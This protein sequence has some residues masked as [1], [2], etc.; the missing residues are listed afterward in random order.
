MMYDENST[1]CNFSQVAAKIE[2]SKMFITHKLLT[3]APAT[4]VPVPDNIYVYMYNYVYMH[5]S[6]DICS[7]VA[8]YLYL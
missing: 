2:H 8:T 5:L 7:R 6:S 1:L 4:S 3:Q